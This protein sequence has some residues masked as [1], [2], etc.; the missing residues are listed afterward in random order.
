M[1]AKVLTHVLAGLVL[2]QLTG[3][4]QD[5]TAPSGGQSAPTAGAAGDASAIIPLIAIDDLPLTDAIKN[6]ARQ[7]GL[8]Y[9]IDPKVGFGVPGPDGKITPQ[10]NVSLRWEKVTAQQALEALLGN[11]SL[12]LVEDPKTRI[13]RV[14]LKDPAAPDPLVTKIIHLNYANPTNVMAA[15]QATIDPKRGKVL[16]DVRTSQLVVVA[17]EKE[18]ALVNEMIPKLDTPTR[19]VLIEA[20]LM[21]IS[22]NPSTVKGIDWSGTF[23]AQNFG[24][25]N[26]VAQ[27]ANTVFNAPGTPT[28]VTLP[29]GRTVTTTPSY[30]S[31]TTVGSGAG[32]SGGGSGGLVPN[33]LSVNT[34]AGLSPGI[35]FLNADGVRGVL[36]FL[37]QDADTQVIS[38][39][40]TVT[41]DNETA[42]IAVTRAV[43]IFQSSVGGVGGGATAVTS[44]PDY[45]NLGTILLVTPRISANDQVRLKIVPEVSSIFR[46]DRKILNGQVSEADEYD[47]RRIETQVLIPSGHTLV[48]GG[49]M[50]DS[51][52]NQYTKVPILGDIPLLGLAFR[53]ENKALEKK[54]LLIFITPTILKETDFRPA[55]TDYL[56]STE[57][58]AV[59]GIDPNRAWE[60]AKPMDWSNPHAVPLHDAN[61]MKAGARKIESDTSPSAK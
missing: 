24:F 11:Y 2:I 18:L 15:V 8:N 25:G 33:G 53:S 37:N 57:T 6:L 13:S 49:L 28:T 43:P 58:E 51:S 16:A 52:K 44:K 50:S 17:T 12:Q 54:N 45:T 22:R 60:S 48:L 38:T 56:Q 10:P 26:G 27:A 31:Q 35:G 32:T 14:T 47:I 23:A 21:E 4:A 34:L 42:T 1:K 3:L 41:L 20:R 29:G 59:S 19:Q 46:T 36:S 40:R 9:M 7:A 55:K 30:D 5:T 39:P 61:Y